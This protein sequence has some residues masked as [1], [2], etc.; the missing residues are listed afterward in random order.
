MSHSNQANNCFSISD[1]F[2]QKALSLVFSELGSHVP[3]QPRRSCHTEIT[4][5]QDFDNILA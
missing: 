4:D 1:V 5:V 2:D 3:K